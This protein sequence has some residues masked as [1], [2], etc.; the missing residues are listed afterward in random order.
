[1]LSDIRSID[2]E[3]LKSF[4]K[5]HNQQAFRVK[6]IL[7]WLWKKAV[8]SF[9]DMTNLSLDLRK[10]LAENFEIR[11]IQT[12][13]I[14]RSQD[15]TLKFRFRL[16]DGHLIESVL[17]PVPEDERYTVCV[18]SQVG[19]SLTCSFCATGKMKRI[20]N[21][22]AAEI[23]DQ[24]VLVSR[25]CEKVY[26]RPITNVVY[27]GM[28]EPLL[29]YSEVMKS[30][31]LLTSPEALGIAPKRMTISTARLA[32]MIRKFADEGTKVN[33]ALSLHASDDAKRDSIM[34]INEHNN[35]EALMAALKYFYEKTGNRISYEYIALRGFNDSLEDAARLAKLCRFFPVRVNIIEYNPIGDGLFDRSEENKVDEFARFLRAKN[36]MVT[37]RRSR[38]KDIDAACGQLAIKDQI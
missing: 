18:S 5:Q 1:M 13:K 19:C 16:Y 23:F 20:R 36:I 25:E 28:G 27:M 9:E 3:Q 2:Q 24:V 34:P 37:V 30:I 12:D 22:D 21:L 38:G 4:L 33:L 15:G 31:E 32:I 35:L 14:Q 17:I 10:L 6:Q 29:A 7:E 8:Y 11:G 26:G